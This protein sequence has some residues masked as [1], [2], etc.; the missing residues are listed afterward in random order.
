MLYDD[1]ANL[2]CYPVRDQRQQP[3]YRN[4]IRDGALGCLDDLLISPCTE[5]TAP[6]FPPITTTYPLIFVPELPDDGRLCKTRWLPSWAFHTYCLPLKL[7]L[8]DPI[9]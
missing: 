5:P 6:A 4:T 3:I 7:T 1:L 2:D 8:S 9:C